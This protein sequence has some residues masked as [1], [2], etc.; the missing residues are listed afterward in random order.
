M[1]AIAARYTIDPQPTCCQIPDPTKSWRNHSGDCMNA[2]GEAE[3]MRSLTRPSR[4]KKSKSIPTT[5]TTEMKCGRYVTVC[6]SPL[7]GFQRSSFSNRARM[8]GAGNPNTRS[9]TLIATVFTMSRAKY[10]LAKKSWKFWSPIHL[11]PSTPFTGL[12]SWNAMTAP[13][14]GP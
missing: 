10:T 14:I 4:A 11:L 5:T 9:R 12:K 2:V 3:A 8:I 1:F 13:Y 6:T 7:N